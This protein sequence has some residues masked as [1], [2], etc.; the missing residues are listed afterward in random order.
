MN[1]KGDISV[2]G[3]FALTHG[4]ITT[5]YSMCLMGFLETLLFYPNGAD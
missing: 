5:L 3:F 1:V 4:A 2:M